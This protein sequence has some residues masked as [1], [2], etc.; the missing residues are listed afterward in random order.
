[1]HKL[2]ELREDAGFTVAELAEYTGLSTSTIYGIENGTSEFKTHVGVAQI[3]AETFDC[4][5]NDIFTS[6]E[7]SH[8]GRPP[9]TGKPIGHVTSM[10][11]VSVTKNGQT[12][13]FRLF[14]ELEGS[15]CERCHIVM[16]LTGKCPF[17]D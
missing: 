15:A 5:V 11:E 3:L 17:C 9:L 12:E 7:L 8:R 14:H 13:T 2:Q 16:P 1:M 10:L 4:D 6:E